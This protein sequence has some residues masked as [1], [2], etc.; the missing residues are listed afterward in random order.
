VP[1]TKPKNANELPIGRLAPS[2]T[3]KLHLGHARTFLFAWWHA[4]SRGGRV[5]MRMEDLDAPRVE[6][7][8][9]QGILRD[10][11]WLGL[12]WDG[13]VVVQS[14]GLSRIVDAANSLVARGLAYPCVCSRGDLRSAQ[15]APQA[16]DAEPR[17]A[18]TCRG[19]FRSVE[20][21]ERVSGK[22]AGLRFLVP[23]GDVT[24][25][26]G[27]AG[28]FTANVGREVGDFLVARKGGAP[29]YQ[30]AVVVDDAAQNVNEVVR[31][32]D[33]LASAAR[34]RLLQR[35][36]GLPE[37]RYWHVPLVVDG[38]GRRLAKRADSL[39]LATLRERGADPRTIVEWAAR[40]AGFTDLERPTARDVIPHFDATR[41]QGA[42][43]RAA[44]VA[45]EILTSH[46]TRG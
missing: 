17:Y 18:G 6:P 2:P 14:E 10:L 3:G 41:I 39:G 1:E 9:A 27:I 45:N 8:A 40:A 22:P 35:A 16:G 12:D 15:S 33:L 37:V 7:L 44:S 29:A 42:T 28:T 23:D 43:L 36:L 32:D 25:D 34:Q 38:E 4:R 19:R 26:D 46:L 24:I 20:E 31:G 13:P 21:A 5:L 30:L 11:E